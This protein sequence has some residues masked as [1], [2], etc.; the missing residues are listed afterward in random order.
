MG[1]ALARNGARCQ[2]TA[3]LRARLS[4]HPIPF[5]ADAADR[6][7]DAMSVPAE[8]RDLVR[9][10]AACS[11]YLARLLERENAWLA[12]RWSAE[13]EAL[14]DEIVGAVDALEGDPAAGLR[15]AK[16]RG[17]LLVAL[18]DLGGVWSTME[19]TEAL[20]RVADAALATALRLA[21]AHAKA[22]VTGDGALVAIAM[23]KMGA[24]ELNYSSD[25]D[26]ILLFDQDRYEPPDYA[27]ARQQLLRAARRATDWLSKVT[28]DGYVFRTDLRL[29]P[30]PASTPI[31]LSMVQ[32][33]RYYEALGRTWERAAHVKARAA[34]GAV[35]AGEAYLDRLTPFVWRRH[36]D[37]A[38]VQDAHDIRL[39]IRAHKGRPGPWDVPGHDVKLGQGGIREI[40]FF[41]QTRQIIAGGRDPSLRPRRTLDGLRRLA[42]AGWVE[43]AAADRLSERY[44]LLRDVEHRLQMV[45]DVQTQTLPADREGL[46]RIACLMGRGDVDGFVGELRDAFGEVEALVD[47]FFRPAA[48]PRAEPEPA[49]AF[50]P[51]ALDRVDRWSLLPALRSERARTIFARLL[52]R[53]LRALAGAANPDEALI[54]FDGFLA[55]LPAGVQLFSL[56]EANAQLVDLIADICALAPDLARHLSANANVLDAVI[57][58]GF[59]SPLPERYDAL[60]LVGEE[61]ETS[62][63]ALRRWHREAHFRVG[64]HLLRGLISPSEAAAQHSLLAEAAVRACWFAAERE[65]ARRYGPVDGL[66]M[67]GLGMGS[68]GAQRLTARSDLDLVV[69]FDGGEGRQSRR[70]LG[71][72][73]WAAKFTQTLITALSAP[74]GEGRLYEVDLRLRP[75][76][77]Q[78]PVAVSLPGFRRYHAEEAWAWEHMALT[79]ARVV[80]GDAD[81]G[82]RAEE[83]RREVVTSGRFADGAVRAQLGD[84]R[85]RL[86][87]AGRTGRGLAVKSGPGR[88]QDVELAAQ[89]HALIGGCQRRGVDEQLDAEG[90]LDGAAREALASAH[91]L[92]SEVVQLTRLLTADDPPERLGT[93]G[94]ALLAR[95]LA[96]AD[97]GALEAEIDLRAADAAAAIDAALA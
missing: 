84:M 73:Q 67:T 41:T 22:P 66:R 53:L 58:G 68:L 93:G 9:G 21:L 77:R 34:A 83:A 54:A 62:L 11:P 48:P 64:V 4:R 89:A 74:T 10:A 28:A 24:F 6:I 7:T 59:M 19:A 95:R 60:D 40:E 29:R 72:R 35:S 45:Q 52:P 81:L 25:I 32:A 47:P 15:Q 97:R 87:E 13:P 8:A 31:V 43:R 69:L 33:E 50:S 71:P 51:S 17:A 65:T 79:R 56:F 90:W 3:M 55:G 96:F 44:L 27:G 20:T 49:D 38:A 82:R 2:A 85:R 57:A 18:C 75:S 5:D 39:G 23:G 30:D 91:R 46:R 26:L 63:N 61:F 16:R 1:Q 76:G 94:D 80:A 86:T 37:F 92:M 14:L 70:G 78:G 42:E 88:M 12:E 36:L